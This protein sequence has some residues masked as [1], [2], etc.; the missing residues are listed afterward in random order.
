[1]LKEENFIETFEKL[2]YTDWQPLFDLMP[3]IE[4]CNNFGEV[5]FDEDPDGSI[6][7]PYYNTDKIVDEFLE[8]V[9]GIPIII[10]FDWPN[11]EEGSKIYKEFDEENT[12]SIL[13]LC[14]LITTIVRADRFSEG[15]LVMA[16]ESGKMG[17][18]L[19]SLQRS[20]NRKLAL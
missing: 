2:S 3:K 13:T 4:A 9:Y 19:N 10:S 7:M 20:V 18:I 17:K 8:I 5:V 16:F 11:W 12:Y 15:E 6:H 14:K 1:M